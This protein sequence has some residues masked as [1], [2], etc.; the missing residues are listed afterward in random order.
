MKFF[1]FENYIQYT[2]S[3]TI[4]LI[5]IIHCQILEGKY[6]EAKQQIEFQHEV[7]TGNVAV[8]EDL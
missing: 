2:L 4:F 3:V 6:D 8:S 7:Q 1:I 5:G